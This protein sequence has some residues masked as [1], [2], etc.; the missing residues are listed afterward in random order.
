M[1]RSVL[2]GVVVTLRLL[3][4]SDLHFG[5]APA[6]DLTPTHAL[7]RAAEALL[8]DHPGEEFVLVISGD[9]TTQGR[10]VGYTEALRALEALKRQLRIPK[11]LV[12]PGN[13]DIARIE[14]TE[15]RDF[16]QFA[17]SLTNDPEQ[18]WNAERPVRVIPWGAY[19][20]VLVNSAYH[21]DHT[22]GRV[23]LGPLRECLARNV[24]AHL[25]VILHHSPISSSYAGGGLSDAYDLLATVTQY[26]ASA[27]FHGH[28]HSD[29]GLPVGR[30]PTIL[31]GAGSLGFHP[32]GN[33]NN[34]FTIHDFEDG[35]VVRSSVYRY[36][37]NIDS[38]VGGDVA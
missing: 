5:A 14:P 11:V 36:Y 6:P 20:F 21:G 1:V 35:S 25:V 28:V 2:E 23:P 15:F 27:I 16:N 24:N 13:H 3:H 17:F 19:S 30:R 22:H 32:D 34:Q 4:L 8:R 29:Q 10:T 18:S 7:T 37:R 31:F 38:F 26:G 12:C 33:M 9:V